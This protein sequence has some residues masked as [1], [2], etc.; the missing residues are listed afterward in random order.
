M[1]SL[2]LALT[3]LLSSV[4]GTADCYDFS[5]TTSLDTSYFEILPMLLF[6]GTTDWLSLQQHQNCG[7]YTYGDI[8]FKS[9]NANVTG[10]YFVFKKTL[11]DIC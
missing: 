9:Y 1:K 8:F 7:F 10:I 3:L 4:R 2:F 11:S 5:V 6:Y